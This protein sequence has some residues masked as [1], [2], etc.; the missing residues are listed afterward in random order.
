MGELLSTLP[1]AESDALALMMAPMS[2]WR[3]KEIAV[4]ILTEYGLRVQGQSVQRHRRGDC[5]CGV[6]R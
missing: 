5:D 6:T 2:G 4:E 3:G 1:D